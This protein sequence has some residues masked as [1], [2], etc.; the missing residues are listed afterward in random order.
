LNES[1][2]SKQ[3]SMLRKWMIERGLSG[4]KAVESAGY[5]PP[6]TPGPLRRNEI[7]I[8]LDDDEKPA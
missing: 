3:E 6:W 2:T 4:S 1:T 5:D 7:L 8:R